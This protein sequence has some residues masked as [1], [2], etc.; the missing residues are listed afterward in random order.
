MKQPSPE[1]WKARSRKAVPILAVLTLLGVLMACVTVNRVVIVPPE[2]PGASFVGSKACAECHANITK[3]FPT[4]THARMKA[5]GVHADNIGCET[6]HGAG[7]LHSESGGARNT[8]INPDRSP[9]VCFQC[10]LEMKGRFSLAHAHPVMHGKM[11][12]SDCHDPHKGQA[13]IGGPF[14]MASQSDACSKCHVA[15]R[16]PFVFE[17]EAVREGCTTCHD[18]HGTPNDKMLV[19]RN[20]N[21]CFK[22]HFQQQ[23]SGGVIL[24][25]GSDHT[26]RMGRG[27]CW[28]AGCHEAVH[29]SH[30]NSSLRF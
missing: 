20:S 3:D 6:C 28:S 26:S 14:N 12:C 29:G 21:L 1:R 9:E 17:H 18:P 4:A 7:S 15:Q 13:I 8:I 5:H 25:G 19:Q 30:I 10:H 2:I 11:S 22:C 24:I 16:G 23:L 27:T